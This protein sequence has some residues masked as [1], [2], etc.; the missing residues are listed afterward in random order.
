MRSWT[1]TLRD[2]EALIAAW[3]EVMVEVWGGV[4]EY[5]L[6][7]TL[8]DICAL[9]GEDTN[10]WAVILVVLAILV[11]STLLEKMLLFCCIAFCFCPTAILCCRA[12]QAWTP[13]YH[14]C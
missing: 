2:T 13:S 12:S 6:I 11:F 14:V 3:V 1:S 10:K 7:R 8:A 9:A 5:T 4:L